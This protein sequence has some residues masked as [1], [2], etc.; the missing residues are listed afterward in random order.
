MKRLLKPATIDTED[1]LDELKY[2]LIISPKYDGIRCCVAEGR[3][4]SNSLKDI[5]NLHI[6]KTLQIMKDYTS[7]M[8]GL[9][10]G[11]LLLNKTMDYNEVQSAV[12]SRDGEPDFYFKLFDRVIDNNNFGAPY[13]NRLS[14]VESYIQNGEG[15]L[16]YPMVRPQGEY[17]AYNKT[18][19]LIDEKNWT[20]Y[21]Y[22]GVILRSPDGKY[23]QGRST[24]KEGICYKFKRLADAEAI[25]LDCIELQHNANRGQRNERG[26]MERS[27][28]KDGKFGAGLLGSFRVSGI[29]GKYKG[30]EFYVSC[31]TMKHVEKERYWLQHPLL[32]GEIITYKYPPSRGSDDAPFEARFKCFRKDI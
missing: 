5:P 22:E 9:F 6:Q 26:L 15:A 16:L 28:H 13:R 24:F 27:S 4:L 1:Q 7:E 21:G 11:E 3:L 12:M 19:V 31:S 18:E 32:D 17:Y 23:K 14:W 30:K 10:D 20:E 2:P 29:N 8:G 25:V